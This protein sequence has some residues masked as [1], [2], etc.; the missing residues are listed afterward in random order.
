M[1]FDNPLLES[2]FKN[3]YYDRSLLTVRV[4]L[5]MGIILYSAFGVLDSLI[6]PLSKYR[7]WF[8]RFGVV[9]PV[10]LITFGLS[11][12]GILKR[13]MQLI[14]SMVSLIA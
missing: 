3:D 4:A 10:L 14:L 11:F 1:R 13:Y 6:T 2:E 9:D 5:I 8:I 12:T 7:I